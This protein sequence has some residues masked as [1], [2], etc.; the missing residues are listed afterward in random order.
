VAERVHCDGCGRVGTRQNVRKVKLSV[1]TGGESSWRDKETIGDVCEP[2][3]EKIRTRHFGRAPTL[4]D[5]RERAAFEDALTLPDFM[6]NVPVDER[7]LE[8]T[9]HDEAVER[10]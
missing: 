7:E 8:E 9:L 5:D 1:I 2:C 3:I 4:L 6:H 10:K